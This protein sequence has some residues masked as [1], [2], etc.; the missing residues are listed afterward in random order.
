[1]KTKHMLSLLQEGFT[2]IHV[3]FSSKPGYGVPQPPD[4]GRRPVEQKTYTYK[5]RL[6]DNI[7]VDDTVVVESPTDGFVCVKVVAVDAVPDIDLDADFEY[8]W[9][10]Q[11]VDTTIYEK[12]NEKEKEFQLA[13][14]EV[15]RQKKRDELQKQFEET[16]PE[17]SEA[18]MI[19]NGAVKSLNQTL[20]GGKCEKPISPTTPPSFFHNIT[21][22][23]ND[24]NVA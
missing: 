22:N 12:M 6:E 23:D 7:Q 5:A 4:Y 9:I 2:T 20:D 3:V 1:M 21:D 17:G 11:K 10:V 19:F 18:W 16:I 13:M 8:K 24:D 15:E 14:Q